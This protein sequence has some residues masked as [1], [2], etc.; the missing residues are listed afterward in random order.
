MRT[1]SDIL[2]RMT[3]LRSLNL[4]LKGNFLGEENI[5]H[6]NDYNSNF[7]YLGVGIEGL[8]GLKDL[9]LDLRSNLIGVN[10]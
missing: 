9:I 6:V 10:S 2:L 1:L 4:N 8:K 5:N 7:K 3:Q